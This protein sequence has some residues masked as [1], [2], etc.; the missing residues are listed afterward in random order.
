MASSDLLNLKKERILTYHLLSHGLR[1]ASC[2]EFY[3]EILILANKEMLAHPSNP[4]AER[5]QKCWA[6]NLVRLKDKEENPPSVDLDNCDLDLELYVRYHILQRE[7]E[8]HL[9]SM[10]KIQLK[11][12]TDQ[13][14]GNCI[15]A[16]VLHLVGKKKYHES[17]RY[18]LEHPKGG[19][20]FRQKYQKKKGFVSPN[21]FTTGGCE[22]MMEKA[23]VEIVRIQNK[24]S[25]I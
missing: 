3:S 24:Y 9:T 14:K 16:T 21:G 4:I 1:V 2:R 25:Y 17:F 6:N 15:K 18:F 5:V 20:L 23:R 13:S 22:E 7:L 11:I 12:A 19:G 8:D 10:E